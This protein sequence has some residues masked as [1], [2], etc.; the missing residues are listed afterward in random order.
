VNLQP[1]HKALAA[2]TLLTC[3][4]A[5]PP[6]IPPAACAERVTERVV[7]AR[8]VCEETA[9]EPGTTARLGILL[10]IAPEWHLFWDGCN[11]TGYPITVTPELPEGFHAR[12]IEWPAPRRILSPGDILDHV[13]EGR[14]LLILPV[15]VPADLPPGADV[16]LGA[17]LEWVSCHDACEIGGDSVSI[18]LPV[19]AHAANGSSNAAAAGRA[20]SESAPLFAETR[21]R[22]PVGAGGEVAEWTWNDDT[23]VVT[24]PGAKWMAFYPQSACESFVDLVTDSMKEAPR[25]E[26]RTRAVDG[27]RVPV[28]GVL[29]I[30]L[31][32]STSPRWVQL[33]APAPQARASTSTI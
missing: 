4:I 21:A 26:L 11:D 13:Y 28:R 9:L 6:A 3:W 19:V 18:R 8:L 29:E 10:Q 15:D 23:L 5:L 32:D 22:V 24:A 14:V 31:A 25:L 12:P 20:K 7:D 30:R 33:S 27:K 2:A 16:S 17:R 1:L